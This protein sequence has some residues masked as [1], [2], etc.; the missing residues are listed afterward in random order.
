MQ[1]HSPTTSDRGLNV[2]QSVLIIFQP[3]R[4]DPN[5]EMKDGYDIRSDVWSFGI[6]MVSTGLFSIF[7]V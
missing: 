4:I 5:I 2:Q 6:T 1:Y 7:N 3:E